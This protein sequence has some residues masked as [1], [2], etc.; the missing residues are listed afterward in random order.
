MAKR[1]ADINSFQTKKNRPT[2]DWSTVYQ[3][4][5]KWESSISTRITLNYGRTNGQLMYQQ[6]AIRKYDN[7]LATLDG[8]AFYPEEVKFLA[9]NLN[10]ILEGGESMII[11]E[12]NG[13]MSMVRRKSERQIEIRLKTAKDTKS[14]NTDISVISQFLYL[15]PMM[16]HVIEKVLLNDEALLFKEIVGWL[17]LTHLSKQEEWGFLSDLYGKDQ[18]GLKKAVQEMLDKKF[19]K[20]SRMVDRNCITFG[21]SWNFK[22]QNFN[23]ENIV[24]IIYELFQNF[25][26][27]ENVKFIQ[28]IGY[29]N[30]F[31][32]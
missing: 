23:H 31:L 26:V 1:S 7:G 2:T 12:Q 16:M 29:N 3:Q 20:F 13:R 22:E 6:L 18:N 15:L 14:F 28:K 10:N 21:I 27:N 25:D 17:A 5:L 4:V 8:I 32:N 9:N 11:F 24:L 19:W 30:I